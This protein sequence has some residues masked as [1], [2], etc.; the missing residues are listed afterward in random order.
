MSFKSIIKK[1]GT[2]ALGIEHVAAPIVSAV[3]PGAAPAILVFD[4]LVTGIQSSIAIAEDNNPADG[5]GP[6]KA[7]T[8]ISD[9]EA[10]L[11]FTQEV[12][13]LKGEKLTYD[14]AALQDAIN[15]QVAAYN[16]MVKIKA[17]FKVVPA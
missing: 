5:Q 7:Q 16:A 2:V 4:K 15:F 3:V 9:F 11:A 14:T 10:G 17:S 13:A 1:I 6:S 8:V 12:L